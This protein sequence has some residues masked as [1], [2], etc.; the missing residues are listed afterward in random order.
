MYYDIWTQYVTNH[1]FETQ[2]GLS[3]RAF[4]INTLEDG[5]WISRN[6]IDCWAALLNYTEKK[7]NPVGKMRFWCYT[8]TILSVS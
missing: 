3:T 6:V 2:H 7:E 8:T 5:K 4:L 1:I